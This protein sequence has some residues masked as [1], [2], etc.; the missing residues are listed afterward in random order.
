MA[1][2]RDQ[3]TQPARYHVLRDLAPSTTTA[4][5]YVLPA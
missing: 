5:L 4:E 1:L 2:A 3:G